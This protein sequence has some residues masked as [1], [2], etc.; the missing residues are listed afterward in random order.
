MGAM[1]NAGVEQIVVGLIPGAPPEVVETAARFAAG[2]NAEL[3]FAWSDTSR[4][5][6][7]DNPDGSVISAPMDPDLSESHVPPFPPSLER[8]ISAIVTPF[9]LTWST[10]LLAGEPARALGKLADT[11]DASMIIVGARKPTLSATVREFFAGSV[12]VH[13]THRQRRPVLVVPVDL[14]AAGDPL[15]WE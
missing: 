2:L 13:L 6:V 14:V 7:G 11:L 5:V 9:D 12:A 15:P 1:D 4:F 3:V 8:L 10:R